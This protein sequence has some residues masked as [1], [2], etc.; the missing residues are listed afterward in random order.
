VPSEVSEVFLKNS[1]THT[2][3]CLVIEEIVLRPVG[4]PL[5]QIGARRVHLKNRPMTFWAKDDAPTGAHNSLRVKR[6][7]ACIFPHTS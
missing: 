2:M 7:V 1:G 3:F 4:V 6:Y 5:H